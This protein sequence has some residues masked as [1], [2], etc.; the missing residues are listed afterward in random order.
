MMT[1]DLTEIEKSCGHLAADTIAEAGGSVSFDA[2]DRLMRTKEYFRPFHW[3]AGWGLAR[4]QQKGNADKMCAFTACKMGL[5]VQ[6]D[7]GYRTAP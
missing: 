1:N 7:G 5:I 4:S 2:Y 6:T 3:A